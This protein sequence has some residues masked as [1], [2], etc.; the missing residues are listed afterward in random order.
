M[1]ARAR[2]Q[3]PRTNDARVGCPLLLT[4][5]LLLAQRLNIRSYAPEDGL[6]G[7][8]VWRIFQ[9]ERGVMWF[10]AEGG[11]Q[12]SI[13]DFGTGYSSLS[14][15]HRFPV[16]ILKIDQS[17]VRRIGPGDEN[18]EIIRTIM[19]LASSLGMRV[20]AEGIETPEQLDHLRGRGC[21]FGQ[22]YYFSHPVD[23]ATA[24]EL[25]R[26]SPRW[27]ELAPASVAK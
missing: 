3:R 8:P 15:L 10:A 17:F 5:S 25:I 13:D 19:S 21:D 11:V 6:A 23:E 16:D 18:T 24:T 26:N 9:D 7:A 4:S 14:Y 27:A 12:W 20:V 1:I 22:G 2:S